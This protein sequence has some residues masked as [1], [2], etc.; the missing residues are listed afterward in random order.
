MPQKSAPTLDETRAAIKELER[1]ILEDADS[2]RAPWERGTPYE[3]SEGPIWQPQR[4]TLRYMPARRG[5]SGWIWA[6]DTTDTQVLAYTHMVEGTPALTLVTHNGHERHLARQ[7]IPFH[8]T[9][10][11]RDYFNWEARF[12]KVIVNL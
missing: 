4:W 9:A 1:A 2:A 5:V 11:F 7:R 10:M 3:P 6:M 12:H 8:P